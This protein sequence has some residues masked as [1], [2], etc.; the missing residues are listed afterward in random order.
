MKISKDII[1]SG[2][3]PTGIMHLGNYLGAVQNWARMQD[4]SETQRYYWIVDLHSI[5]MKYVG[6]DYIDKDEPEIIETT[7][8]TAASLMAWG[9][10]IDKSNLFVQSHVPYHSE[11]AWILMWF[12]PMSWLNKMIQFKE[13]KKQVD[14]TSIALFN[15]PWLMAA[16]IILYQA[17]KVPVG[18][19]QTQHLELTRDLIERL[20]THAE[21][22]LPIPENIKSEHQRVMSLT[23]PDKKMS[24]SDLSVRS[25]INL[26]DDPEMIREKIK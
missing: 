24:K 10:D 14:K 2:I 16:D 20:N 1:M 11:L 9:I 6:V 15:Y 3:Q 25:R 5:T 8:K 18:D 7:L 4:L 22:Q 26:I 21:L 12:T 19:D 23:N 17:T 13:K